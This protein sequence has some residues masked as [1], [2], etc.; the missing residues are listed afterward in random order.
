M[1]VSVAW[2]DISSDK[3]RSGDTWARTFSNDVG[4]DVGVDKPSGSASRRG[5]AG[6]SIVDAKASGRLSGTALLALPL[7]SIHGASMLTSTVSR[8][9]GSRKGRDAGAIGGTAA[10]GLL[11]VPWRAAAKARRGSRC[12]SGNGGSG[13]RRKKG[14]LDPG[15][16]DFHP[17]RALVSEPLQITAI[18]QIL[19]RGNGRRSKMP[20][21]RLAAA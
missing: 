6:T 10:A 18:S 17:P 15:G 4:V 13:G 11:S 21:V 16:D 19:A 12:S 5:G 14:R 2:T 3:A 1:T 8:K 9:G 7:T 20:C